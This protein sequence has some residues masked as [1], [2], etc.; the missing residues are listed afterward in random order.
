[1]FANIKHFANIHF[2]SIQAL[3]LNTNLHN[4]ILLSTENIY[5]ES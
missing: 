4:T 5:L 1:M 2:V 3:K